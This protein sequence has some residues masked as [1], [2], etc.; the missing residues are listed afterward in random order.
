MGEFCGLKVDSEIGGIW[1]FCREEQTA[2]GFLLI[3]P[4]PSSEALI[5][6]TAHQ[7]WQCFCD[8][9]QDVPRLHQSAAV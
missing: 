7:E 1:R 3:L 8:D 4:P 9:W 6:P 5:L 2:R